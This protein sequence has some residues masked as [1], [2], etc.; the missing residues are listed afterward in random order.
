MITMSLHSLAQPVS[1]FMSLAIIIFHD[2][3]E[4]PESIPEGH[5]IDCPYPSEATV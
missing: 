2:K 1:A 3:I 4:K 5:F